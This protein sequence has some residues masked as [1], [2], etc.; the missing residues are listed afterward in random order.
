MMKDTVIYEL[1]KKKQDL[2]TCTI[3]SFSLDPFNEQK[4][5]NILELLTCIRPKLGENTFD[6]YIGNYL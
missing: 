2:K 1:L 5:R 4:Q 6:W 3:I